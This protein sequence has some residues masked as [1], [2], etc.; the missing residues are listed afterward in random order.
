MLAVVRIDVAIR[1][2]PRA[3]RTLYF[4]VEGENERDCEIFAMQWAMQHGSDKNKD[5]TGGVVMPVYRELI[6]ILEI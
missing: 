1:R 2:P 5:R 4:I 6:E 3:D